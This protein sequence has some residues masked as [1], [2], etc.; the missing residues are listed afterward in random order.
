MWVGLSQLVE[1]LKQKLTFP[2]EEILLQDYSTNP[3]PPKFPGSK[4]APRVLDLL[5]PTP[6]LHEPIHTHI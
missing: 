2:K 3:P 1:G 6:S 4:A 5:T